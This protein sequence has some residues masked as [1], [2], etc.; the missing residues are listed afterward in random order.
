MPPISAVIITYNEEK[1][2]EQCIRSL[3]PVV[4]DIVV[5]DSYSTDKTEEICLN[6]GVRFYKN[7]FP[8]FR[9]QKNLALQYAK[10]DHILS[11]DADEALSEDL[12]NSILKVKANWQYDAYSFNRINNYCG[13]WLYHLDRHAEKIIRLFDKRKGEWGGLN[14]HET[15][16]MKSD[17]SVSYIKGYLLH[18]N[19]SSIEDHIQKNN[20]Y[21]TLSAIEYFKKGKKCSYLNILISPKW[22]FF[23]SYILRLGFLNGYMGYVS[24]SLFAQRNFQKYLKL[25]RLIIEEKNAKKG[26]LP[27]ECKFKIAK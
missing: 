18:W 12:A 23:K 4:D 10:F 24:C 20:K 13:K 27:E 19:Y 25:K 7:H 17:A 15:V 8:G 5:L 16:K 3:M 14:I 21:S 2:I 1:Y 26:K 6:L 9:E 22:C 11:L